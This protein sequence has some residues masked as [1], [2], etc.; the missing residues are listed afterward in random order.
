MFN[1]LKETFFGACTNICLAYCSSVRGENAVLQMQQ[2][3]TGLWH[4]LQLALALG[5]MVSRVYGSVCQSN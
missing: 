1:C 4:S 3:S 2:Q 5:R